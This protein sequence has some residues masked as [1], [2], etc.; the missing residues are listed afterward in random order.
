[1]GSHSSNFFSD[2]GEIIYHQLT[3]MMPLLMLRRLAYRK[4]AETGKSI[5]ARIV[6]I[7]ACGNHSSVSTFNCQRL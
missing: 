5:L 4:Y 6:S 1:M 7:T 2:V 3:G